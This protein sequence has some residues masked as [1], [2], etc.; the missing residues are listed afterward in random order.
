MVNTLVVFKKVSTRE[1]KQQ[2][3]KL[4]SKLDE[5]DAEFMIGQNNHEAQ[6]ASKTNTVGIGSSSNDMEGP[7]QVNTSQVDVH[8]L[9]GNIFL[10]QYEVRWIK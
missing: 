9:E 10:V 6:V 5:S 4:F 3:K 2:K 8:K 1:M 7:I